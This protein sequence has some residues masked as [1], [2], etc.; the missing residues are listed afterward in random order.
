MHR[1]YGGLFVRVPVTNEGIERTAI[2]DEKYFQ[3]FPEC[4]FRHVHIH[5]PKI[6]GFMAS[7][8]AREKVLDSKKGGI[9][10]RALN[11]QDTNQFS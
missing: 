7:S 9:K 2:E 3:I 8:A 10:K 4:L 6:A 11:R 1:S 5:P